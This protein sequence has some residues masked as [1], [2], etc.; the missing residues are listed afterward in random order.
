MA[1]SAVSA[2]FIVYLRALAGARRD[3]ARRDAITAWKVRQEFPDTFLQVLCRKL[4]RLLL[5]PLLQ[6]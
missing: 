4:R 2:L 5:V 3:T 6:V 1:R